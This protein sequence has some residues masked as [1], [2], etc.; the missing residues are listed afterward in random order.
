[1][2]ELRVGVIGAGSWTEICHIPG[3]QAHPAGRV[4]ALCSR[5]RE[6]REAQAAKLGISV[7]YGDYRELIADPKIDAVTIS[8]PNAE[9][10]PIA[11]AALQAGKHVFCE[12]PL[13]LRAA[14][15]AELLAHAQAHGLVHQ[16]AF[17]FRFLYA[18]HEARRL[19]TSGALGRL[20]HVR[21][22]VEG[23]GAL[24][25]E[26]PA[27][28]RDDAERSGYGMLGDMGSH[29][30]DLVRFVTDEELV[31][32]RGAQWRIGRGDRPD[33][34]RPGALRAVTADE[35]VEALGDLAGG[36][37]FTLRV[38]KLMPPPHRNYLDFIGDEAY[39]RLR[40]SRGDVDVFSLGRGGAE[41]EPQPLPDG[42]APERNHCLFKMMG[43]FVDACLGQ[44]RPAPCD[45]PADFA[46]GWAVQ[47]ALD[48][49]A[50]SAASGA[51]VALPTGEVPRPLRP[52]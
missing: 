51:P 23:G 40:Y 20:Q 2:S 30:I 37:G 8:T 44:S 29:M 43:T 36:A 24:R 12:K 9:H 50:Q 32:I 19:V 16:V 7:T 18:A 46:D 17:T 26:A 47:E 3:V 41:P 21:A 35:E 33:P 49:V 5:S 48:A 22:F 11:R 27:R 28:W 38:S 34:D 1:M 6:R 13:T 31:R 14:E 42:A 15:S 10:F 25:P 45:R 4:V 52:E 39:V